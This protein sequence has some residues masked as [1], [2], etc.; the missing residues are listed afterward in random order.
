MIYDDTLSQIK[1]VVVVE[2]AAVGESPQEFVR[3]VKGLAD[4]HRMQLFKRS[5][6]KFCSTVIGLFIGSHRTIPKF[7]CDL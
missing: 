1:F 6:S 2:S 5:N 7:V 3:F 4:Y